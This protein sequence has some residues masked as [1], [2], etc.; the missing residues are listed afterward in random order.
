MGPLPYGYSLLTLYIPF[1]YFV[2]EQFDDARV[3]LADADNA[4]DQVVS[5]WIDEWQKRSNGLQ[6]KHQTLNG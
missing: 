1:G 6:V 3:W 4:L 5:D 2:V